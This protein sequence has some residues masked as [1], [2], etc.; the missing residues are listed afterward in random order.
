MQVLYPMW[1]QHSITIA[2]SIM[3]FGISAIAPGFNHLK[4]THC[5]YILKLA[6]HK[7]ECIPME[8]R[9]LSPHGRGRMYTIM[10]E[11]KWYVL[12]SFFFFRSQTIPAENMN[13]IE[14]VCS[15]ELFRNCVP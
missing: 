9:W 7:P 14:F 11:I 5:R 6:E 2:D 8:E 4:L 15:I 13:N 10:A 3:A 1:S 12:G